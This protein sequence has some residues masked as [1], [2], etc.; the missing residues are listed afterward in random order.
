[1]E[2]TEV[3][4]LIRNKE[5]SGLA[6]LYDNYSATLNGIITRIVGSEKI[7]EEVLQQTFLKIWNKM[8]LY[9]SEKATLFT[10]MVRIARNT[11][12][13]TR[14]LKKFTQNNELE[15]LD[16]KHDSSVVTL[17]KHED[18]DAKSLLSKLDTKYKDVLDAVYLKGYSQA[19]AAK[20]LN[21][22]LGTVKTRIRMGL[23]DLR[24]ELSVEKALFVSSFIII[25]IYILSL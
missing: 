19:A 16:V 4:K 18:I 5:E 25:L 2:L 15:S 23:K 7:A 17:Q 6:F 13:D 12:I 14:R 20:M 8:D 10:W 21:I 3:V 1:M 11:A 22:P 24:G 9:D